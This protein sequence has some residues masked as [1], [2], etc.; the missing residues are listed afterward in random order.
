MNS[1][2]EERVLRRLILQLDNQR[3]PSGAGNLVVNLLLW[4][5]VGGVML[6]F[7]RYGPPAH[8]TDALLGGA[9]FC[10][11]FFFAYDIYRSSYA[12]QWPTI[13]HYLDRSR[14]EE[15]LRELG[16]A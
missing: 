10:F 1:K 16:G 6:A 2:L 9:F 14:I 3:R 13:S 7:F 5:A 4:I 8:W 11:G 12:Q 15:R